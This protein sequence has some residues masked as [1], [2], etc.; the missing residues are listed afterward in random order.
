[1][2]AI[3][4]NFL[5]PIILSFFLGVAATVVRSDLRFPEPLYQGL[6]MYLL[7]AIGMKGGVSLVSYPVSELVW[8][9][10]GALLLS[11]AIPLWVYPFL[12]KAFKFS[13]ADAAA[14]GA[15]Y[16][17]VSIV[18]FLAALSFLEMV[19]VEAEGYLPAVVAIMEVPGIIVALF[20]IKKSSARNNGELW[21]VFTRV[22]SSKSVFLLLGGILIGA[23]SGP[24]GFA[25]VEG[26]FVDPFQGIL[27]LFLLEMGMVASRRFGDIRRVGWA[28]V[29]FGLLAPIVNAF[30]GILLGML[31]GMSLGGATVLGVLASSASYIAA[32]AT[33]RLALPEANPG[34]YLTAS[35]AITFPFNLALGIPLYHMM[36]SWFY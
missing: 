3:I 13:K 18:T 15:H 17:S 8:P 21:S 27:C 2:D 4:A 23:L 33:V 16:G 22:L 11:A 32:P 6:A 35:L 36:A 14:M 25:K 28:L 29:A 19:G 1:M 10:L 30:L 12:Q 34:Y 26:F 5:S 20:L 24:E 7:L 9:L 31:C